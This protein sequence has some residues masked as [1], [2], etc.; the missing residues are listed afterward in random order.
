MPAV[1]ACQLDIVWE[2]KRANQAKVEEMLRSQPP[3]P[4]DLVVLPELFDVGFSL[5]TAAMAEQVTGG[6]TETWCADLARKYQIYLQGASVQRPDPAAKATN[7]AVV[8]NPAGE[9]VCRY[10]KVHPFSG[11]REPEAYRGG[12]SISSFDWHGI[13]VCPMI[14]YDLRFPELWRAAVLSH[15][16]EMFTIGASWPSTRQW[17]WSTLLDA[18]AI[19]NQAYVVAVNRCG[20]DPYLP[21]AGGSKVVDPMGR[22]VVEADD[23]EQMIV[24]SVERR[25]VTDWRRDFAA[26]NDIHRN[27]IGDLESGE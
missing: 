26:L 1:F 3:Q 4:D 22:V 14:C 20:D 16:A 11:G 7:N 2:D 23:T 13:T 21:Y 17:H 10:E 19:E 9:I 15:G 27:L 6:I 18:R 5:N 25:Q 8:F 12:T 24:A